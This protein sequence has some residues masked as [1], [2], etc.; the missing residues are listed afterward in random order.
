MMAEAERRKANLI[1]IGGYSH[2]RL[3]ERLLGGVTYSLM[4]ESP[5][6]LLVAH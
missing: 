4:H 6:A 5:I 3:L 2:M 1:V